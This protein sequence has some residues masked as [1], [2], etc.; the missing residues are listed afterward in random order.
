MDHIHTSLR[1]SYSF[2]GERLYLYIF[3]IG[4]RWR[5]IVR[6]GEPYS[7]YTGVWNGAIILGDTPGERLGGGIKGCKGSR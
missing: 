5:A 4:F 3:I 7:I 2:M 1:I 6:D